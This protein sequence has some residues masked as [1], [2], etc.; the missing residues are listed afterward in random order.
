MECLRAH[1]VGHWN[2]P[3]RLRVL[4]PVTTSKSMFWLQLEDCI[5]AALAIQM[6]HYTCKSQN[7][8]DNQ[9]FQGQGMESL[10]SC[11]LHCK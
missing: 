6:M 3:K 8:V 5:G 1:R 2:V 7:D 9:C 11:T 4:Y 10:R